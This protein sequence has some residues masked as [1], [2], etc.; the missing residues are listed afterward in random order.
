MIKGSMNNSN[1]P[2]IYERLYVFINLHLN[3]VTDL[4]LSFIGRTT[5][6]CYIFIVKRFLIIIIA[7]SF[8]SLFLESRRLL[9]YRKI[10]TLLSAALTLTCINEPLIPY[11]NYLYKQKLYFLAPR[12]IGRT[13]TEC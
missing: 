6:F 7:K 9:P 1:R 4:S 11:H 13:G 10:I 5:L 8:F 12:F 2:D 3:S